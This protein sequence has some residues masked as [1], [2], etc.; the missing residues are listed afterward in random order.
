LRLQY[1][2]KNLTLRFAVSGEESPSVKSIEVLLGAAFVGVAPPLGVLVC[3]LGVKECR[4]IDAPTPMWTGNELRRSSGGG[5]APGRDA[6][7]Y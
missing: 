3:S 1:L 7:Q 2:L 4:L 5:R 6:K